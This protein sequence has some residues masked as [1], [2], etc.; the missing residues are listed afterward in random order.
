M[1]PT[2][3]LPALLLLTGCAEERPPAPTAEEAQQLD[4]AEEMLDQQSNSGR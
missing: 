1:R 3:I 4:D 2:L